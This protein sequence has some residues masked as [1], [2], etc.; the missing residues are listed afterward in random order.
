MT[1]H[2]RAIHTRRGWRLAGIGGALAA[3]LA[4]PA[5]VLAGPSVDHAQVAARAT[6]TATAGAPRIEIA[7]HAFSLPMVTVAVGATVTWVNHDEDVHT[8]ISATDAFRSGALETDDAYSHT[9]TKP[10][11]YRYFCS[12][13]PLMTGAVVVK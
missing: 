2:D 3:V 13:H 10:G 4:A 6:A 12:L 1:H 11:V 7:N 9:F 5:W 8:I